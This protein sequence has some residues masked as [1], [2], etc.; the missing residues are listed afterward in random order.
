MK[1][2]FLT[3]GGM[4]VV[5]IVII[6][7]AGI[8]GFKAFQSSINNSLLNELG[9]ASQEE[10][11]DFVNVMNQPF[12]ATGFY[13]DI[14]TTSDIE[15][16]KSTLANSI[17]LQDG[18]ALFL[19]SGHLN[20][21][22]IDKE[23]NASISTQ[24]AFSEKQFAYFEHLLYSSLFVNANSNVLSDMSILSFTMNTNTSH[25]VVLKL[26]TTKLKKTL[27]NFSEALPEDLYITLNYDI[28]NNDNKWQTTNQSIHF[29]TLNETY[30]EKCIK[31]FNGCMQAHPAVNF[32]NIF[33]TLVNSFDTATSA[34]TNF[35][36]SIITIGGE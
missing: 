5:M 7:V 17:S 2:S 18:S 8:L 30:N 10:Y 29:N 36:D 34:K 26:N 28:I 4:A 11:K 23:N 33:I 27:G 16:V 22:A 3:C 35:S 24:M 9:F 19:E 20:I 21:D 1:K 6:V 31:F 12:D 14:Y 15:Y 25:K 32:S 13:T